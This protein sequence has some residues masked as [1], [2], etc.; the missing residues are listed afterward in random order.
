MDEVLGDMLSTSF[1]CIS[2][3][4]LVA[5]CCTFSILLVALKFGASHDDAGGSEKHDDASS[6]LGTIRAVKMS[7][8]PIPSVGSA[9]LMLFV[10]R[11]LT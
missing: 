9:F 4:E 10:Q 6:C 2:S 8:L 11:W 5:L 7:T 1:M 3:K